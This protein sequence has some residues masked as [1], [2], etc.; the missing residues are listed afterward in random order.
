MTYKTKF[1][2]TEQPDYLGNRFTKAYLSQQSNSTPG[3]NGRPDR[4]AQNA[5][6]L[7]HAD[8]PEF[9]QYPLQ[10]EGS[11]NIGAYMPQTAGGISLPPG[12]SSTSVDNAAIAKFN[13]KIR[14]GSASM[15]VTL[16]SWKQSR[17]M[18]IHR[19]QAGGKTLDREFSRLSRDEKRLRRL[20]KEQDPLANQVLETEFGWLPLFQDIKA[21]LTTVCQDGVPPEWVGSR[22]TG[23]ILASQVVDGGYPGA[24][25][26]RKVWTGE[27]TTRLV[28]NVRIT[29][30]NVWLMNR[31]GLINPATVIWDLIPW[32]FLVNMF[33]NVNAMISSVTNYVGLELTNLS[34]TRSTFVKCSHTVSTNGGGYPGP[35]SSVTTLRTKQRDVGVHPQIQWEVRVPKLDWELAVIASSLLLQKAQRLNKLIKGL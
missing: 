1:W 23:P 22:H 8:T 9:K 3:L 14:K 10:Q 20:K 11:E 13:G 24:M 15:G 30:P 32:S 31:M 7:Y 26:S 5:F 6:Y 17:D 27:L 29:N 19:V 16:A 4:R 34:T 2:Y 33:V 28:A 12:F 21:A 18:I 25:V 35:A